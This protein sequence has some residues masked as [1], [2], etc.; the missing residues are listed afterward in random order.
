MA[1]RAGESEREEV[2]DD[3]WGRAVS[4]RERK[5]ARAGRP[6]GWTALLGHAGTSKRGRGRVAAGR[7]AGLSRREKGESAREKSFVFLFKNVNSVS[8]CLFRLKF[9]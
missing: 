5:S 7:S 3:R 8:I 9:L 6:R 4:E 1:E 2:G